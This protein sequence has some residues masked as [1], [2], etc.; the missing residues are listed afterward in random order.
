MRLHWR[1]LTIS[2]L[3]NSSRSSAACGCP[4]SSAS[5]CLR[6]LL[7]DF[8]HW[9]ASG[10]ITTPPP[11]VV[12]SLSSRRTKRS[13]A[14]ASYAPVQNQL[15]TMARRV[16]FA[17][18]EKIGS[19]PQAPGANVEFYSAQVFQRP[20]RPFNCPAACIQATAGRAVGCAHKKSPLWIRSSETLPARF[21]AQ[22]C[23][24]CPAVAGFPWV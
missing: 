23:P 9:G 15:N 7:R 18:I 8:P 19:R 1:R 12:L 10:S 16:V 2:P 3:L 4:I 13:P 22:R 11:R 21:S 20:F 14:K 17:A 5:S 24:A 6:R